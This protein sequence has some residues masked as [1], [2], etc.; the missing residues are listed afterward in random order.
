VEL[1]L[2]PTLD[3]L[4]RLPCADLLGDLVA[5][6]QDAEDACLPFAAAR[7]AW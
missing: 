2:V 6:D 5:E 1:E 3:L 4:V 7:A